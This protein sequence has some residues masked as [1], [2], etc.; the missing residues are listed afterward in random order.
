MDKNIV[1]V[2]ICVDSS[3]GGWKA[4]LAKLNLHGVNLIAE[5]WMKNP[6][7]QAYNIS[8]IPHYCLIDTEGKIV[9][10]NSPRPSEKQI[11]HSQLDKLLK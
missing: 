6:V 11:L 10:I 4:G 9:D 2:N 5:G 1:F 3:E 7:C 8:G